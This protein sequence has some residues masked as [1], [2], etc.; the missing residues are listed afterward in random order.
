[1]CERVD[2]H[3]ADRP[4]E[5]GAVGAGEYGDDGEYRGCRGQGVGGV[6]ADHYRNSPSS[7]TVISHTPILSVSI[8]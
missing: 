2:T 8:P 4:M 6:G 3:G 7:S 5:C 1:M